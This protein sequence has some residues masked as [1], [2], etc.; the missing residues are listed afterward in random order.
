MSSQIFST[1][2]GRTSTPNERHIRNAYAAIIILIAAIIPTAGLFGYFGYV[3]QQWQPLVIVGV[4]LVVLFVDIGLSALIQR[5]RSN[6]AM[7]ILMANFNIVVLTT[8]LLIEGLG[9]V[10]A[11]AT[12]L[13][14]IS[15][16]SLTLPPRYALPGVLAAATAGLGLFLLDASYPGQRL[17]VPQI[18]F[19]APYITALL[20]VGFIGLGMGE[21]NRLSLRMKIALGI[22]ATGAVTVGVLVAFGVNRSNIITSYLLQQYKTSNTDSVKKQVAKQAKSSAEQTNALFAMLVKDINIISDYR[23]ALEE[24]K[25]IFSQGTYWDAKTRLVQLPGG[26]YGNAATDPASIFIPSTIGLNEAILADLSTTAYFDF[27]ALNYLKSHPEVVSVYFISSSGATT[28][29]PNIDLANNVPPDF[30][31]RTQPFYTISD[32][33]ASSGRE[34]HWV[35]AYQDPAGQGLLVTLSSPV[36]L[37]DNFLGVMGI[38]IQLEYFSK[39]IANTQIGASGYAFLVDQ[40]GH[41]LFMPPQGYALFGMQAENIAVNESPKQSIIGKGSV[42]LQKAVT[43]MINSL[44]GIESIP[45]NNENLYVAFAPLATPNYRLGIIVPEKEFTAD[46]IASEIEIQKQIQNTLQGVTIILFALFIGAVVISLVMGQVITT[47]LILLTKTV[48]TISKGNLAARAN[49]NIEAGDETGVLARAFNAMA[50]RLSKNL[51]TLEERV[52]ERTNELKAA[53]EGNARRASQFESVAH[54]ARTISSTQTLDTLLPQITETI[55]AEFNFY[56]VGIFLLDN[57]REF[58]ILV[59]ANSEGGQ[60]MLARNHRLQVGATGIVGYVTNVGQPR[61]AL[62]VGLDAEYFN[63]PDLPNTHSEIA[64]P[65]RIG[66]DIF[67]AL[68]VQSTEP[69]AFLQED[70]SILSTLADQVSVA[71]QNARSYQQS[72][73]ALLQAENASYQLSGQQWK[74]F[75]SNKIVEGYY[76]DGIETKTIKTSDKNRPHNLAIPLTLRGS[77]IGLIKLSALDPNREWTDDEISMIQTAAERTALALENARLLLESQKRASK[78]RTIGEISA[79]IGRL[80]NLE[81]ILQ[82]AVQELG[83]TLPGVDVAVQFTKE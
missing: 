43:R 72:S 26:Q 18:E 31:P 64:L 46:I 13:I 28:Y 37:K 15:I 44:A 63:N 36:Y 75:L 69:N 6:L 24:R 74:R 4:L 77:Q 39:Q 20:G 49:I 47:P 81:S 55:S 79:K 66:A 48:E 29:Y 76:F 2:P 41:I 60:R 34:P 5:G 50:E 78:E 52:T 10:I 11:V 54:V 42:D 62:D 53:N 12:I 61:V 59:A 68:D 9:T 33:V 40:E 27:Y 56:H 30:D 3:N 83:N 71:I 58:A 14:I 22:L 21:F 17:A 1:S 65:L 45:V 35:K 67:G 16:S 25:E 80:T 70:I 23:A 7:I 57:R 19:Y 38:D 82:T 8:V 32:P 73:A 51:A